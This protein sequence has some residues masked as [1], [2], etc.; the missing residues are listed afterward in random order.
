[1][2]FKESLHG[3]GYD[4]VRKGQRN[5]VVSI[6]GLEKVKD[7]A[8]LKNCDNIFPP[9]V[10]MEAEQVS[11]GGEIRFNFLSCFLNVKELDLSNVTGVKG[12]SLEGLETLIYLERVVLTS[13][14]E[15]QK[16][17]GWEMLNGDYS[18]FVSSRSSIIYVKN[19]I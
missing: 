8:P 12:R 18:K 2:L 9:A 15:E 7:F 6:F 3:L 10:P 13:S 11:L 17:K 16:T 1:M 19:L 4:D 5:R 14:W